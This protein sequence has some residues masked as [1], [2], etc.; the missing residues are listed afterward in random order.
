[1]ELH[2]RT[3]HN[4]E[5]AGC[6]EWS[7]AS[8]VYSSLFQSWDWHCFLKERWSFTPVLLLET[9]ADPIC[10]LSLLCYPYYI[11][12]NSWCS[13]KSWGLI[14][15]VL[16]WRKRLTQ[17][18]HYS[19]CPSCVHWMAV[20]FDVSSQKSTKRILFY[21]FYRNF[22]GLLFKR[23]SMTKAIKMPL[24]VYIYIYVPFLYFIHVLCHWWLISFSMLQVQG[25]INSC[26]YCLYKVKLEKV[27]VCCCF[28][29]FF[30]R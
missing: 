6:H 9:W 15:M 16:F 24:H 14:K 18:N 13:V 7:S 29:C 19:V 17:N 10:T 25:V 22:G 27:F 5:N 4:T 3:H 8:E 2:Q 20:N 1:M 28:F 23:V 12:F 26:V 30:G 21:S 11:N